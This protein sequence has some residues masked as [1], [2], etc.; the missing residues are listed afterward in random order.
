MVSASKISPKAL[1]IAL[2]IVMLSLF[3]NILKANGESKNK[4]DGK[5]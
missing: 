2:K 5:L 3:N 4:E 1:Q